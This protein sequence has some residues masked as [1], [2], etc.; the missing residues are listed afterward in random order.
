[1]LPAYQPSYGGGNGG[2]PSQALVNQYAQQETGLK[3]R[4]LE[5]S[6]LD[7]KAAID[8]R[9]VELSEDLPSRLQREM[10]AYA[11]REA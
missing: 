10:Q 2:A 9:I 8:R 5:L 4:Q 6:H 11:K 1:L 7:L 3:I